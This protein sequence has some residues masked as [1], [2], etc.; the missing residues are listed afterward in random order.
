MGLANMLTFAFIHH[1][2]LVCILFG[3]PSLHFFIHFFLAYIYTA[4]TEA[5][6]GWSGSLRRPRSGFPFRAV[7]RKNF[8]LL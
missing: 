6:Q 4:V 1:T 2:Y 7:A 5:A 3:M 8:Y